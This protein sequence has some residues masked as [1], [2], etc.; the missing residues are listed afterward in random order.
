MP[1]SVDRLEDEP[2]EALALEEGTQPYRILQFLAEHPDLAFTQSE[3]AEETDINRGS[4]G[5]VL[6]RLEDRD[7]VRHK[8]RYWAIA[9]DDRLA[10][11]AAQ[12]TASAASTDDDYYES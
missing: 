1:I 8:G 6:S 5:A 4:V 7:L 11:F 3:L 12:H 9:E 2:E 10:A